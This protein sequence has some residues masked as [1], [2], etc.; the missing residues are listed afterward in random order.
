MYAAEVTDSTTG[1]R[2]TYTGLT[3]GKIRDRIAKHEGNCRNRHQPST[4][5]SSHIWQLKDQG[6]SYTTSWKILTRSDTC[7][8][9][10]KEKFHINSIS[11][12]P[13]PQP[14]ST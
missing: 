1:E 14:R 4:R 7:R 3:D 8:L 11:C 10:M 12:S 5:L 13:R 9:C 6:R 2:E